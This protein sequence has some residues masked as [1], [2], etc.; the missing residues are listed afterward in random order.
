[1]SYFEDFL[2][3]EPE[4]VQEKEKVPER[5][6]VVKIPAKKESTFNI[7]DF[8]VELATSSEFERL[9][10]KALYGAVIRGSNIKIEKELE[11]GLKEFRNL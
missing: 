5:K 4:I 1:M 6:K 11:E 10:Y 9:I 8:L 7:K 3:E 2:N